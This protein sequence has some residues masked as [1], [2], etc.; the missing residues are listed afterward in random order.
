MPYNGIAVTLLS[1]LMST[2]IA[3]KLLH[4]A[5]WFF[6][7]IC[8]LA[9]PV[10]GVRRQFRHAAI[11]AAVVMAEG[12]VLA[13]NHFRCPLSDLA[14]RYTTDRSANFDIYL[15]VWL[16]QH[17]ETIF[18]AIFVSGGLFV[19]WQWRRSRRGQPGL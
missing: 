11:L 3:I 14:A 6:F 13:I 17:N 4:T 16:A 1:G 2:L 5:V 15:P 9:L 19:L 18:G 8:I 10:V 7:A 12:V